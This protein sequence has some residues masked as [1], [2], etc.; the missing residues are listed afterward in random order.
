MHG[1]QFLWSAS[2]HNILWYR[3]MMMKRGILFVDRYKFKTIEITGQTAFLNKMKNIFNAFYSHKSVL[4]YFKPESQI[5]TTAV[6]PLKEDLSSSTAAATLAP[7]EKPAK[8]PS[9]LASRRAISTACRSDTC[10]YPFMCVGF[11]SGNWGMA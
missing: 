1:Q 10:K 9:S 7:D 8:I 2:R 6:L 5:N 4:K 11:S 3:L